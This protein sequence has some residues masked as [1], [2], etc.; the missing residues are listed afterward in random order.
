MKITSSGPIA[1]AIPSTLP[2]TGSGTGLDEDLEK[3]FALAREQVNVLLPRGDKRNGPG[4]ADAGSS[5]GQRL[6]LA[7]V[8]PD[9]AMNFQRNARKKGGS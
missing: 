2:E 7:N 3:D 1:D 8:V 6:A 5:C 4:M 9:V